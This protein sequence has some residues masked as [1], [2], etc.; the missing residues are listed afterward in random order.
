MIKFALLAK[1][2]AAM[3]AQICI[4]YLSFLALFYF[5]LRTKQKIA[6]SKATSEII[7]F[8]EFIV[9]I[10]KILRVIRVSAYGRLL[11]G[12]TICSDYA[13]KY[14]KQHRG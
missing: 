6:C 5:I 14:R 13:P 11:R 9:I 8:Q 10:A 7:V 3:L 2:T 1:E 4:I 12:Q